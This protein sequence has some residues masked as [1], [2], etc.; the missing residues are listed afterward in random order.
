MKSPPSPEP[1]T[2]D[3]RTSLKALVFRDSKNLYVMGDVI[4]NTTIFVL[5][6]NMLA[7]N[8]TF[9]LGPTEFMCN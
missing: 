3:E 5:T 6:K 7:K 2:Q 1:L 8:L 4:F 9:Y